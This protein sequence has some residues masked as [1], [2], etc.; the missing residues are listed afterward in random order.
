[1]TCEYFALCKNPAVGF[2]TNPILGPVPCCQRCADKM[3]QTLV[4][5]SDAIPCSDRHDPA[6]H[7]CTPTVCKVDLLRIP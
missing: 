7:W 6:A 5:V 2:V 1:M 4:A 3:E